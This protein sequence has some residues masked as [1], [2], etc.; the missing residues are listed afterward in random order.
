[1]MAPATSLTNVPSQWASGDGKWKSLVVLVVVVVVPFLL[2]TPFAAFFL[3]PP[4]LIFT[5][6]APQ[7]SL[8]S[9]S[10]KPVFSSDFFEHETDTRLPRRDK[11]DRASWYWRD[12]KWW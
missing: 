12:W 11:K 3:P 6:G 8:S 10:C 5:A 2:A 9:H 4:S 7:S 1:M